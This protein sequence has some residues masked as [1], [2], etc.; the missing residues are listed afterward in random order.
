MLGPTCGFLKLL[1]SSVSHCTKWADEQHRRA[2]F[3]SQLVP[4]LSLSFIPT[5]ISLRAFDFV[6]SLVWWETLTNKQRVP[7]FYN[8]LWTPFWTLVQSEAPQRNNGRFEAVSLPVSAGLPPGG[9]AATLTPLQPMYGTRPCCL[10]QAITRHTCPDP[11]LWSWNYLAHQAHIELSETMS[12]I[13]EQGSSL[14]SIPTFPSPLS[15][16]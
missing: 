7:F 5:L 1:G 12:S 15:P 9:P 16:L 4:D 10:V 3:E 13:D 11:H 8:A 2:G 14:G 6:S